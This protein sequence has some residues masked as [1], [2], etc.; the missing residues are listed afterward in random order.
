MKK[1][2]VPTCKDITYLLKYRTY[3]PDCIEELKVT[4][5]KPFNYRTS[6][7]KFFLVNACTRGDECAYS[8]DT[9]QFPCKAFFIRKNCK[10]KV[11]MFSHDPKTLDK[12][13]EEIP[14]EEEIFESAFS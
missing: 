6:L 9:S 8:H 10:R 13:D 14:E 5:R 1:L 2:V 11:C 4:E 7:C 3:S 12:M